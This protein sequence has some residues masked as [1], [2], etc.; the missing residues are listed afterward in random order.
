[1]EKLLFK[2]IYTLLDESKAKEIEN[3]LI[4]NGVAPFLIEP[5]RPAKRNNDLLF[6]EIFKN[7]K[8]QKIILLLKQQKTI[9]QAQKEF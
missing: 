4:K 9:F 3:F 8:Q 2:A 6:D 5:H 7:K 1:M